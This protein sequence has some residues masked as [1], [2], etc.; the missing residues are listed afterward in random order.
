MASMPTRE[1]LIDRGIRR[2]RY[3]R[4][5]AGRELREARVAAGVSQAAL[6][7]AV[8]ISG[9]EV[10]R[11]EAGVRASVPL[12]RL[13]RAFAVVGMELSVRPYPATPPI[14]DAAHVELLR[15]FR[16]RCA[17]TWRWEAE[18]PVDLPGDLRAWDAALTGAD[19]R[20]GVEAETRVRD[21]QA[22]LRRVE[23]KRRDSH[24]DRVL[25]VVGDTRTNRLALR[26][27]TSILAASFRVSAREALRALGSGQDPGADAVLL[28]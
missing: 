23:G 22:L 21:I 17:A 15:R 7:S 25:V 27:S 20:I 6:G 14:R 4:Q 9:S 10:S 8:G 19:V 13:A 1:R 11:I 26:A 18:A 28:L 12:D 24:L 2:G 5:E 16:Q 3:L